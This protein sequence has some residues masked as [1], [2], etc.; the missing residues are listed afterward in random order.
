M[1]VLTVPRQFHVL[2]LTCR[3]VL[4]IIRSGHG[5]GSYS[6]AFPDVVVSMADGA[7]AGLRASS[8]PIGRTGWGPGSSF[9]LSSGQREKHAGFND[10]GSVR[11]LLRHPGCQGS[12][13]SPLATVVML[14]RKQAGAVG[15]ELTARDRKNE[16]AVW[17]RPRLRTGG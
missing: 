5:P 9:L 4:Y 2:D 16:L 3:T 15:M 1:V 10:T 8:G 7:E 17:T 11:I 13:P 12:L 6:P 14:E